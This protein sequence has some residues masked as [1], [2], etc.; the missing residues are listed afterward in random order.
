M[1]K[2]GLQTVEVKNSDANLGNKSLNPAHLNLCHVK[3]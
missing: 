1:F 3:N 2:G